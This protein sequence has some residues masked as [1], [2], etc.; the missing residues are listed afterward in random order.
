MEGKGKPK[1]AILDLVVCIQP[2]GPDQPWEAE[3]LNPRTGER[4][5][6]TTPLELLQFLAQL[7]RETGGQV[8]GIR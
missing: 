5:P 8:P 1:P 6:C 3:V 4:T 7:C 2:Q